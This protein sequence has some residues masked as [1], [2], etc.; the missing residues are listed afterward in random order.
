MATVKS[1]FDAMPSSPQTEDGPWLAT[2]SRGLC[3]IYPKDDDDCW[4]YLLSTQPDNVFS[5]LPD[6]QSANAAPAETAIAPE[7]QAR[8]RPPTMTLPSETAPTAADIPF[9][10]LSPASLSHALCKFGFDCIDYFTATQEEELASEP[11]RRPSSRLGLNGPNGQTD[12]LHSVLAQDLNTDWKM[13]LAAAVCGKRT[14][15]L[16]RKRALSRSMSQEEILASVNGDPWFTA[17]DR[18]SRWDE[19]AYR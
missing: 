11:A 5:H 18:L 1:R 10:M 16:E 4:D 7:G 15:A 9:A 12:C 13:G 17:L 6:I 2:Y 8:K 19:V 14:A 3:S